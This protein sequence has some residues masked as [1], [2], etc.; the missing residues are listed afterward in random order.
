MSKVREINFERSGGSRINTSAQRGVRGAYEAGFDNDELTD[1]SKRLVSDSHVV[2]QR[3]HG[4]YESDMTT[5]FAARSVPRSGYLTTLGRTGNLT[6]VATADASLIGIGVPIF[7]TLELNHATLTGSAKDAYI[8]LVNGGTPSKAVASKLQKVSSFEAAF[9]LMNSK[10]DKSNIIKANE[11]AKDVL[12]VVTCRFGAGN[13]ANNASLMANVEALEVAKIARD[14][15]K[16]QNHPNRALIEQVNH[17]MNGVYT[18]MES[19]LHNALGIKNLG[20][21]Q[22]NGIIIQPAFEV[23]KPEGGLP[24]LAFSCKIL[25]EGDITGDVTRIVQM[26][27]SAQIDSMDVET[28]AD[29]LNIINKYH[30]WLA[31]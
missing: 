6:G 10:N 14:K 11:N 15:W 28:I 25:I 7:A 12:R 19:A 1:A 21:I 22:N 27:L 5:Y 29:N 17:A 23:V 8:K 26:I 30:R 9:A 3:T 18:E 2:I 20:V 4:A 13:S 31:Q 16:Y 24:P